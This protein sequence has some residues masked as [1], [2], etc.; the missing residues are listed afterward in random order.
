MDLFST[1][2]TCLDIF[3]K[4]LYSTV[5]T[6]FLVISTLLCFFSEFHLFL[7]TLKLISANFSFIITKLIISFLLLISVNVFFLL[8]VLI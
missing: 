5:L 8:F 7:A 1:S 6:I 3:T 4:L 2:S